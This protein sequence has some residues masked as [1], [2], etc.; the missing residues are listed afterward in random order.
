[1]ASFESI[2]QRRVRKAKQHMAAAAAARAKEVAASR[3][4]FT[5]DRFSP[6][7][8]GEDPRTITQ[9]PV[10]VVEEEVVEEER[11]EKE[12]VE[13]AD[14]NPFNC[15]LDLHEEAEVALL[16]EEQ[17]QEAAYSTESEGEAAYSTEWEGEEGEEA[18]EDTNKEL[19]PSP[20]FIMDQYLIV[21][22]DS[23]QGLPSDSKSTLKLYKRV[24]K[25][26]CVF[27]STIDI[28]EYNQPKVSKLWIVSER[29]VDRTL[30]RK[31]VDFY[32]TTQQ[33][34]CVGHITEALVYLQRRLSDEMQENGRICRKGAIREDSA[35]LLAYRRK[36]I[37]KQAAADTSGHKDVQSKLESRI[38]RQLELELIDTCYDRTKLPTF[39]LLP[40]INVASSFSH[41]AQAGTRG[42]DA[43]SLNFNHGFTKLMEFVGAGVEVDHFV[44]NQGKTNRTGR[45]EYKAFASHMNPRLDAAAHL[46]LS[47]LLRFNVLLEPFPDFLNPKD[48]AERPVY[49]SAQTYKRGISNTC[50]YNNWKLVFDAV[51]IVCSKVTHQPRVDLQQRIADKGCTADTIEWFIGYAGARQKMN[52]NQLQSYLHCP[53]VQAVVAAADGDP[54]QPG[55]H[56]PGWDVPLSL[57]PTG[58]LVSL[59]PWLYSELAKVQEAYNQANDKARDR[60]CLHQALG[61]L[62]AFERRIAHA[63]K[64]VASL[65]LDSKN[66]LMSFADPIY[67]QW[68]SF[69]VLDHLFFHSPSFQEIVF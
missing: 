48:Y 42:S 16:V 41:A 51:G 60:E 25:K 59:C 67:I 18:E 13:E 26:Y 45:A 7:I 44:H 43:R 47:L 53:P 50:M 33:R 34:P 9:R 69:P 40:R 36:F 61:S 55:S 6:V 2:Q 14:N 46:G 22:Q 15:Y 68:A 54:L 52:E 37:I 21:N 35:W 10:E 58:Q 30:A 39:H 12:V 63:V 65:P 4:F 23:C 8:H 27:A 1:M 24:H 66:I 38:P 28:D 19:P 3:V 31:F 62:K 56:Q 64:L 32:V 5:A 11:V 49:R 57:G 29:D 20:Q 17:E